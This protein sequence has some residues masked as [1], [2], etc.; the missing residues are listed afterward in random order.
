MRDKLWKG[1]DQESL[2]VLLTKRTSK[3]HKVRRGVAIGLKNFASLREEDCNAAID[4]LIEFVNN[5]HS[6]YVRAYAAQSLGSYKNSE[7][8]FNAIKYTLKQDSISDQIRY[9]AFQGLA[10]MGDPRG[11]ELAIEHLKHGKEFQGRSSAAL[12]V[13]KLGKEKPEALEALYLHKGRP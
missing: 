7:R 1:R 10:E 11:L 4:A 8:A 6:H 5:D 2:D 13:G 9:R 3:D 12:T